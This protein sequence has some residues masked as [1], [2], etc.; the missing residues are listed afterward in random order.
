[1]LFLKISL[2]FESYFYFIVEVVPAAATRRRQISWNGSVCELLAGLLKFKLEYCASASDTLNHWVI[3][4]APLF[5]EFVFRVNSARANWTGLLL[6]SLSVRRRFCHPTP[7]RCS[8]YFSLTF[9]LREQRSNLVVLKFKLRTLAC[10]ASTVSLGHTPVWSWLWLHLPQN[11][12]VLGRNSPETYL[13]FVWFEGLRSHSLFMTETLCHD[14]QFNPI[15]NCIC[16]SVEKGKGRWAVLQTIA[17]LAGISQNSVCNTFKAKSKTRTGH[18][19][20]QDAQLSQ[21]KEG[22]EVDNG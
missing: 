5:Y 18:S 19:Q 16:L 13:G 9:E 2:F 11:L 22:R 15:S 14:S 4:P 3:F 20:K 10:Q 8:L 12:W 21:C 17:C 1:M 7:L 6:A